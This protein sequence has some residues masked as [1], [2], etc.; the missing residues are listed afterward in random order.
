MPRV[1]AVTRLRC[2]IV[3]GQSRKMIL[4]PLLWYKLAPFNNRVDE[5]SYGSW[6]GK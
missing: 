4:V 1:P 3:S 2:G 5:L 6:L